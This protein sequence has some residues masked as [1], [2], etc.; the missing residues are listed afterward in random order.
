MTSTDPDGPHIADLES[1][2]CDE[3]N[4]T[5]M[6]ERKLA[7]SNRVISYVEDPGGWTDALCK[8]HEAVAVMVNNWQEQLECAGRKLQTGDAN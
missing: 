1:P 7:S 2:H 6:S 3:I 8:L 5:E 4:S